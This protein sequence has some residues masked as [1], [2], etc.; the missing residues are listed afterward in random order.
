MKVKERVFSLFTGGGQLKRTRQQVKAEQRGGDSTSAAW[1]ELK[2]SH[3]DNEYE[4]NKERSKVTTDKMSVVF[5]LI[6]VA[7]RLP[8]GFFFLPTS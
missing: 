7:S 1:E 6:I 3:I 8:E 4:V 5:L 2:N